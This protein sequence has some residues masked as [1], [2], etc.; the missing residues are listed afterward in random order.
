MDSLR[1]K[2]SD[3]LKQ[4]STVLTDDTVLIADDSESDIFFLLRAFASARVKNP[5]HV[6]R[7][8]R[9]A[10][11]YLQGIGNFADKIRFPWP[12]VVFVDLIMPPPDGFAVLKWKSDQLDLPKTL[13]VAMSNFDS[14]KAIN[15]AYMAG[16]TTFLAKPLDPADVSNLI[17][18][19]EDFWRFQW[20]PKSTHAVRLHSTFPQN[21][22]HGG[23]D[24]VR[25]S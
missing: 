7:S 11:D 3:W 1:K 14:P 17:H 22:G 21:S 16:A 20:R 8:G 5:I 18:G 13:W 6:V 10:L 15:H 24:K 19:Y 25:T 4:R 12:A 2:N 9:E 23:L